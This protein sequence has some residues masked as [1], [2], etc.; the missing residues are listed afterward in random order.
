M[1]KWDLPEGTILQMNILMSHI[2]M[3]GGKI[4]ASV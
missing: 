4:P 1:E 2:R 3:D